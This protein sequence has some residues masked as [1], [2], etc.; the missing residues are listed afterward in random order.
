MPELVRPKEILFRVAGWKIIGRVENYFFYF[1]VKKYT[2]M[3]FKMHFAFQN[4]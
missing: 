1:S 2:F 4:A 3:H